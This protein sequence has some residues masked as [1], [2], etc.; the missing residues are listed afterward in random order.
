LGDPLYHWMCA[1][2]KV[3]ALEGSLPSFQM[4]I[5]SVDY[6]AFETKLQHRNAQRGNV[7]R[8]YVKVN[9]RGFAPGSNVAAKL[10]WADASAGLPPLPLDFWTAFPNNSANTTVLHPLTKGVATFQTITTLSPT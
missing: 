1:D 8:A 7:N 5:T 10:L 3:D 6:L 2:I 4:P 9:N